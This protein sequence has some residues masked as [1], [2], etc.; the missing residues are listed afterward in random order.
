LDNQSTFDEI[1]VGGLSAVEQLK[2]IFGTFQGATAMRIERALRKM[3]DRKIK[4]LK[5]KREW[6]IL[7]GSKLPDDYENPEDIANIKNAE[8]N[9]GD[10]KLKTSKDFIVPEDQRMNVFKAVERLMLIKD[11]VNKFV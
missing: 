4:R 6:K 5:R 7:L 10:F 3:E 11:Y 8:D 9:L 1:Q 2:K